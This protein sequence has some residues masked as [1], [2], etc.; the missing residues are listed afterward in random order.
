MGTGFIVAAMKKISVL[1]A[2]ALLIVHFMPH[3]AAAANILADDFNSATL[4]SAKW[5]TSLDIP[6][7]SVALGSGYVQMVNGGTLIT[8]GSFDA[9]ITIK[10]RF[11]LGGNERSNMKIVLRTDGSKIG[12]ERKG[13]A[14]QLQCRT[15]WEGFVGQLAIFEIGTQSPA[16][17]NFTTP[18]N[19]NEWHEVVIVDRGQSVEL[20]FDGTNTP[21]LTLNSSF[22]AGRNMAVYNREGAAAGSSISEGGTA[23]IDYIDISPTDTDGDGVNDY[24]EGKD[25]TDPNEPNS[26][27]SL[28]KG[29]VASYPFDGHANDESGFARTN[30]A[31]GSTYYGPT[32]FGNTNAAFGFADPTA[33]LALATPFDVNGNYSFAIWVFVN[34]EASSSVQQFAATGI[35]IEGGLTLRWVDGIGFQFI[36]GWGGQDTTSF[37]IAGGTDTE[38]RGRWNHLLLTR[39]GQTTQLYLNGG[40]LGELNPTAPALD[41]GTL[42]FGWH[43]QINP[44]YPLQGLVDDIHVYE[45][46]LSSGEAAQLYLSEAF[47]ESQRAFVSGNPSNFDHFS[48]T[49]F[50]ANRT[51]GQT[52]VT[53]NPSAYG[54]VTQADYDASRGAGQNDVLSDPSSYNLF[55]SDSIMDLN[56]GGLMLQK[57]GSSVTLMLEVQKTDNLGVTPFSS[58]GNFLLPVSVP[59]NKSFLRVRAL[60][61]PTPVPPQ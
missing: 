24:R 44:A 59:G 36:S 5:T 50:N 22:S 4:E 49:E 43:E 2:V 7:S 28:S 41:T 20:Y 21:L 35:D 30:S 13:I 54:L 39:N 25:G 58:Y 29:L 53:T 60:P 40:L 37:S 38:V 56:L 27:N 61:N 10:A 3:A 19:L 32:R 31:S 45:R 47:T 8:K 55:T 12:S 15:D 34:T 42:K 52:D 51:N 57:Q 6:G 11:Q 18:L 23:L 48:L 17:T 9:P 14:V 33:H 46:S 26:F 1:P 16:S